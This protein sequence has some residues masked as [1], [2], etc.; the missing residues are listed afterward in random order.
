MVPCVQ[1]HTVIQSTAFILQILFIPTNSAQ[2]A[3]SYD[4]EIPQGRAARFAIQSNSSHKDALHVKSQKT[5]LFSF[6]FLYSLIWS[7]LNLESRGTCMAALLATLTISQ[8][9]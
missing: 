2:Q 8:S 7:K 3:E 6:K 5:P 9:N 4:C 1:V